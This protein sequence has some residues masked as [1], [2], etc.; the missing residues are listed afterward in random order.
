[1]KIDKLNPMYLK[2]RIEV[3]MGQKK[4]DVVLKNAKYVNV[5]T[6]KIEHS[7]IAIFDGHIVGIGKYDG[8]K[9]IDCS[10]KIISPA[11]LI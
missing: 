3:S 5:F 1:M 4:A 7:D 8:V 9:E 6:E 11:L 2:N 10:E